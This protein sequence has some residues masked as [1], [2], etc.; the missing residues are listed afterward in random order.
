MDITQILK[1]EYTK[2]RRQPVIAKESQ[3][4][5]LEDPAAHDYVR[6]TELTNGWSSVPRLGDPEYVVVGFTVVRRREADSVP[7]ERRVFWL[8]PGDRTYSPNGPYERRC[9]CEAVDPRS[10]APGLRGIKTQR[11]WG[12]CRVSLLDLWHENHLHLPDP[13]DV[14]NDATHGPLSPDDRKELD[15][16]LILLGEIETDRL[17]HPSDRSDLLLEAL[18]TGLARAF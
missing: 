15:R 16:W 9:P 14:L 5:W 10:L 2:I 18:R 17:G 12:S 7:P 1:R 11:C 8:K 4:V 6:M 13:E 3:L